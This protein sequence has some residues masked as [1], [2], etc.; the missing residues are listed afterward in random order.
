MSSCIVND[1][2]NSG[3]WIFV[4]VISSVW[5]LTVIW[6]QGGTGPQYIVA[7]AVGVPAWSLRSCL[8]PCG[9]WHH[10]S[11]CLKSGRNVQISVVPALGF[12]VLSWHPLPYSPFKYSFTLS[13]LYFPG[14]EEEQ[15]VQS[16]GHQ[17]HN[18]RS[19]QV[20]TAWQ[21][22]H[23]GRTKAHAAMGCLLLR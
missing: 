5:V 3:A 16:C 8:G 9:D 17:H 21:D 19:L 18:A 1:G 22:Q 13:M 14:L 4:L 6:G 2:N 7:G 20:F 11:A 15:N 10:S 12:Y 23:E